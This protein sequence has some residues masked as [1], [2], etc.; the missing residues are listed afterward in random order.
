MPRTRYAIVGAGARS[1]MYV[2]A[3]ATTYADYAELVAICEPNP[4]RR[5]LAVQQATDAGASEPSAWHPDQL[6]EL[7]AAERV[8]RVIITARDDL[9]AQLIV[10]AL[11][12]GVDVVVEKPL[13]VNAESAAAIE[14]AVE[15]TGGNVLLTFNYRYSPRNSALRQVIQDGL[16]GEVTSIDFQWM[17]DTKHG[18]DYFRR[19]HR[20]KHNSGG[21]LVHKSSHHFDL[22]NWWIHSTPRRVY[23]SGGLRF[24][25]AEN[26]SARG[27][28]KRADRGT[29]D[30][31]HDGFDLDLR[32]N[33]NL[34]ALY[35][36]AEGHDGYIRDRDVFGE[37][38]TIEDNLA[39]VVDYANGATL[40]YSLNAHAPW[41]GYRVA[42]NGTQGRVELEVI[43]RGAVLEG[44][45]LH[46]AL[47]PSA[48]DAGASSSLRP[49]GERLLLQRH[50][51]APVEIDIVNG[52]GGHGGGDAILLADIFV[53]PS[54]DPLGRPAN[55]RDG[56]QSIAVGIAGNRSLETGLPVQVADLGVRLLAE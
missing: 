36:D 15:R 11:D 25:G 38:I 9:H 12:A 31:H 47:D 44:E 33:A 50:W 35:L 20:E 27:L 28:E 29:H 30:G 23:A 41:E 1:Q 10:R 52:D 6:E 37:G 13:T 56:V 46:P 42:V 43:E 17:L 40:S 48:V 53:G 22:V 5:G 55:W 2:D 4:T 3:I 49:E 26:A 19:W 14:E 24:Y 21:L 45:G 16:I 51:E 8:D 7:I 18:A 32:D 54:F 34:K 39:L